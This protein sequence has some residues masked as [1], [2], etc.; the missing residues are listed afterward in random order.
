MLH[1]PCRAV[2]SGRTP[3][4]ARMAYSDAGPW[5]FAEDEPVAL[6]SLADRPDPRAGLGRTGPTARRGSR[7]CSPRASR[8]RSPGPSARGRARARP[9]VV[10]MAA[11]A[12]SSSA[13]E[14][15]DACV[16]VAAKDD[17]LTIGDARGA[18]R[19]RDRARS[20]STRTSGLMP[21]RP[22]RPAGI[23]S[24]RGTCFG[25]SRSSGRRS[26]W[27]SPSTRSPT[28]LAGLPLDRAPTK[29][30]W[31][32]L[33]RA[34]RRPARRTDG[35]ARAAARDAHVVASAAGAYRWRRAVCITRRMPPRG[36]ATA[37]G[38]SS[39]M[40]AIPTSS[41]AGWRPPRIGDDLVRRPVRP[42]SGGGMQG[43]RSAGPVD[44]PGSRSVRLT[45]VPISPGDPR[46]HD[47]PHGDPIQL[48]Q[49][50]SSPDPR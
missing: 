38:S 14:V 19:S 3:S 6:R 27:G 40:T 47:L 32:S 7:C 1:E 24:I 43:R 41:I 45:D 18:Q 31:A 44:R 13:L 22:G 30:H 9:V 50:R 17:V 25:G 39:A 4:C 26:A 29:A 35:R 12:T 49:Q 46:S 33:S 23:A 28:L 10:S 5:P 21:S 8:R 11:H 42:P 2:G 48:A 36:R 16:T 20:A 37:R 15:K 34:M